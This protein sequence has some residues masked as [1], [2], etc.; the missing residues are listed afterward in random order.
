MTFEALLKE[1]SQLNETNSGLLA[2]IESLTSKLQSSQAE[3]ERLKFLVKKLQHKIWGKSSERRVEEG[4]EQGLLFALAE[5]ARPGEKDISI[6]EHSRKIRAKKEN[7]DE[8]APEGTFPEYLPRDEHVIDEKPEGIEE[9]DLELISQKVTERLTSTPEQHRVKRI[10]RNVYKQKSTGKVLPAPAAP[11]HVLDQRCKVDEAFIVLM[12][13]K[14]FLWHLP[15]F[16]QQQELALQGI[17]LSRDSMVRWVIEFAK[18]LRP[19]VEAL[20]HQIRGAPAVHCDDTAIVVG[21]PGKEGKKHYQDG[22]LWPILAPGIGVTFIYRPSRGWKEVYEVLKEF[23]GILV[24]DAWD[25]FDAYVKE[26]KRS[27]QLCWMH[28]RRNFIEAESSNPVLAKEARGYIRR[29]YQIETELKDETPERRT[30]GRM[31]HSKPILDEFHQWLLGQSVSPAV[32][33]DERMSKAVSYVLKRWEAACLFV[34]DGATP[35]D[36]GAVERAIRPSKLGIKNW[37]HCTSEAGAETVAIFYSLIGSALMHG[38]HP[39][40]YLLDLCKRLDDSSLTAEDL[41]PHRWKERFF[42]EA[43]PEHLRN[44]NPTGS[45]FVG[46]P[47]KW[48]RSL[49]NN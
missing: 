34:Y 8:E 19:I 22:Y 32:I 21:K 12:I 14:K 45:P 39:Y 25:G 24:S 38:I 7:K 1:N 16:R 4:P 49:A 43:V 28:I 20:A 9:S 5:Q 48:H 6:K 13:V 15:I 40:Y 2:D 11:G 42:E 17:R 26:T 46:D 41:V 35:I 44:L 27:W 33:T 47:G 37:L 23:S 29:L 18:L 3:Q 10:V 31:R 36:N 30:I